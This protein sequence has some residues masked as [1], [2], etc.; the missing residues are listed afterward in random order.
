MKKRDTFLAEYEVDFS[1]M[2]ASLWNIRTKM[3]YLQRSVLI[4]SVAYYIFDESIV[5]DVKYDAI[6]RQLARL[7]N[8]ASSKS[9]KATEF[10]DLFY[11]YEGFTG[12]YLYGRM[13]GHERK[14]MTDLTKAIIEAKGVE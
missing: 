9:L 1:H 11:D 6:G 7:Q 5:P 3:N 14:R 12:F 4:L 8:R 13:T 2:P 10:Y